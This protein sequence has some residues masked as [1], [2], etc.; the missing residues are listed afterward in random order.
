V[1]VTNFTPTRKSLDDIFV[2]IYG[3]EDFRVGA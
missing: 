2:E 1:S 3:D